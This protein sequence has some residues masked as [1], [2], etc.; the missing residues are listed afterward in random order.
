MRTINKLEASVQGM[1][2]TG[3]QGQFYGLE[4]EFYTNIAI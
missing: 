4:L 3:Y 1:G 2:D